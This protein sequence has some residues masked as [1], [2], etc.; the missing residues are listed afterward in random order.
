M[1]APGWRRR[2]RQSNQMG[3][4][5]TVDPSWSMS[6]GGTVL[7]CSCQALLDKLLTHAPNRCGAHLQRLADLLIGP[8]WPFWTCISFQQ[9]TC[10]Q[11]FPRCCFSRRNHLKKSR[12]F[13]SSEFHNILFIHVLLLALCSVAQGYNTACQLA[14]W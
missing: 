10:V 8:A 6:T 2:A 11:Q 3:F 13:L 12:P 9:N 5:L 1:N 14:T 4:C 7:Q